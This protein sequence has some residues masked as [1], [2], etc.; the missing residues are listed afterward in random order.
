[1]WDARSFDVGAISGVLLPKLQAESA[2]LLLSPLGVKCQLIR[3]CIAAPESVIVKAVPAYLSRVSFSHEPSVFEAV[4]YG[5]QLTK[6]SY[7]QTS[8]VYTSRSYSP[9]SVKRRSIVRRVDVRG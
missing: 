5:A 6:G 8:S 2:S 9:Y 7:V 3:K 4:G 1:M